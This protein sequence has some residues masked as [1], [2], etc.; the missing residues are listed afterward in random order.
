MVELTF[1]GAA[2]TV[3]GSRFLVRHAGRRL[4]V[5]CGLFQGRKELRL[6]NWD[7][8][9]FR[10]SDVDAV[11]LTHAHIDH[12][13]YLPR[14]GA[15][16]FRGPVHATP[17][18]AALCEL[19]LR[20]A[21]HIQEEDAAYANR[22][23]FSKHHPALPLFTTE[24]AERV[25]RQFDRVDFGRWQAVGR[26]QRFRFHRA[27]HI[28]GSAFVELECAREGAEPLRIVF[29]GD[30]GRYDA[31][32]A[33]D[34]SPPPACDVLVIESTYGDRSHPP[35][36]V[37]EQLEELLR[38]VLEKRG[39]LLFPSFAVGRTQQLMVLLND[40]MRANPE[41]RLPVHLDSPMAIDSTQIYE[42][43]PEEPG[44]ESLRMLT[45]AHDGGGRHFFLHRTVEESM[46]LNS[47]GGPRVL[48]SS[49]G[50]MTGGRVLHHLRRLLPA[51]ENT[52]ALPGY[53]APGTR[54]W[55]LEQG[56]QEIKIHGRFVPVRARI[57][58]LSGLSA[59]ADREGLLRWLADSPAPQRTFVVHGDDGAPEAFAALLERRLKHRC[60]VPTLGQHFEL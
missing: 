50:M 44:L 34:P 11:A 47:M 36:P 52:I 15:L 32:L 60:V 39:T 20:D 9:G 7:D 12:S 54:G 4:L 24:D 51:P 42:R 53:M 38:E 22:K 26:G 5:D 59:H 55:R 27:G 57:A 56:E 6:R 33:V 16:G 1:H 37:G 19:M 28:L 23:G 43:Y 14:L 58:K 45:S 29:S 2:G 8:P 31:P 49:S 10:P 18:T 21:A 40:V 25:L 41:L 17:Q 35:R 46:Q 13:G 48:I 30:V 3:T